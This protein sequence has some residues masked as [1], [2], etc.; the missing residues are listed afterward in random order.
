MDASAD[1]LVQVIEVTRCTSGFLAVYTSKVSQKYIRS[2]PAEGKGRGWSTFTITNSLGEPCQI[3]ER[4]V[5]QK[6]LPHRLDLYGT[7]LHAAILAVEKQLYC[8]KVVA[9][10]KERIDWKKGCRK[11]RRECRGAIVWNE[12]RQESLGSKRSDARSTQSNHL[13]VHVA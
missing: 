11:R 5:V 4:P 9:R 7:W 1:I 3:S 10:K 2:L 12:L 13:I 6:V 8:V